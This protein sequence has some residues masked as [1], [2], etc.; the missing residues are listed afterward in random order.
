MMIFIM[1]EYA[2]ACK[3]TEKSD[4]YNFR[5]VLMELITGK[6]PVEPEFTENRCYA[7]ILT[8][9]IRVKKFH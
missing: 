6:G 1:T 2:Y 3:M 8:A 4:F 5:V 7:T 9:L